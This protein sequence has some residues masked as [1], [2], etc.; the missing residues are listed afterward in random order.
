MVMSAL[1]PK[2]DTTN[3][4]RKGDRPFTKRVVQA[5]TQDVRKTIPKSQKM[6]YKR[7]LQSYRF[8]D[9]ALEHPSLLN[10][11]FGRISA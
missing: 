11:K 10:L 5:N 6:A 7:E 9:L 2:A 1:P 3:G 8:A 4:A